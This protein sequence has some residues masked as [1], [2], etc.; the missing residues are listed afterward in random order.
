MMR[1]TFPGLVGCHQITG[2]RI[3]HRDGMTGKSMELLSPY[4][5]H[6]LIIDLDGP[7]DWI[8]RSLDVI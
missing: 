5:A 2:I 7:R 8:S 6:L 3:E 1:S 4:F